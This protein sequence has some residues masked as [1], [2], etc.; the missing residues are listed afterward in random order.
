MPTRSRDLFRFQTRPRP[1]ST[2]SSQD[3]RVAPDTT[4]AVAIPQAPPLA[5]IGVAED[6]TADGVVRT[7]IVSG[8]NDV[9]LVKSGETI[10]DRYRIGPVSADAVQVIDL[11][12][13]V[14]ISLA[15][16]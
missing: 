1:R 12:T 2:P 4:A 15:L 9:F 5:L 8:F 3:G 16:R 14:S 7:A 13:D 11:T 10:R 6:T